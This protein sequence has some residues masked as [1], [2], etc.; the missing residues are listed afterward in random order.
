MC[1]VVSATPDST[2]TLTY[3]NFLKNNAY[4]KKNWGLVLLVFYFL[5]N[6]SKM[7]CMKVYFLLHVQHNWQKYCENGDSAYK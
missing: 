2:P 6:V 5:K 4:M 3:Q 1:N 7:G